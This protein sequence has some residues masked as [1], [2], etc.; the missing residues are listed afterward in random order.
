MWSRAVEKTRQ[1]A[2]AQ[3]D[4]DA[5]ARVL[6]QEAGAGT[7]RFRPAAAATEHVEPAGRARAS[8]DRGTAECGGGAV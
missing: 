1:Y 3:I 4:D 2:V 5:V 7:I 6:G 8:S